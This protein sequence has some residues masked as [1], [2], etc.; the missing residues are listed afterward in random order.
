MRRRDELLVWNERVKLFTGSLNALAIGL[1]GFAVLRP[2]VEDVAL[3]S[4]LS[5]GWGLV[6]VALHVLAHYVL[7]RLARTGEAE[8]AR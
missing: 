8:D 7:G 5:V 4:L 2:V 1:V 6:G 3:V